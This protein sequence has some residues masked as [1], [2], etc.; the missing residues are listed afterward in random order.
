MKMTS[1][2]LQLSNVSSNNFKNCSDKAHAWFGTMFLA[3]GSKHLYT[4]PSEV[5][6]CTILTSEQQ[7]G[8]W[9]ALAVGFLCRWGKQPF[10]K[11]YQP[12]P[13]KTK[14]KNVTGVR[15]KACVYPD[16]QLEFL[17]TATCSNK[18]RI[19]KVLTSFSYW[20]GHNGLKSSTSS[21]NC[22][23]RRH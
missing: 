5:R 20:P 4:W 23:L 14:S 3:T 8:N 1:F 18:P 15:T 19:N 22:L 21:S 6:D 17:S 9:T 2:S 16:A 10:Y 11:A 13:A 12:N 7:Q